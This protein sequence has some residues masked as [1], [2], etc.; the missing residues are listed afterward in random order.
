MKQKL[1]FFSAS[2]NTFTAS[3]DNFDVSPQ[4][5]EA[6]SHLKEC[7]HLTKETLSTRL[8]TKFW[9]NLAK[10]LD[11]Y[12][13]KQVLSLS[14]LS[15]YGKYQFDHDIQALFLLFKFLVSNPENM[16]KQ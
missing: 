16:F 9:R 5:A 1:F 2:S 7:L 8:F 11:D 6:L 3:E 14:S 12:L 4:I 15:E 10:R 13:L